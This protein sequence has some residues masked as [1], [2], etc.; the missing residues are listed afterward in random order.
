MEK[1]MEMDKKISKKIN[2]SIDKLVNKVE[3]EPFTHGV[4]FHFKMTD[5]YIKRI[6]FLCRLRATLHNHDT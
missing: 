6:Q 5:K 1:Y 4:Y 3:R 2:R